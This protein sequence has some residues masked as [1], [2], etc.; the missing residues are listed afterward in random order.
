MAIDGINN[1]AFGKSSY[2]TE[3]DDKKKNHKRA[4]KI[5]A[6]VTGA[7]II[8]GGIALYKNRN[9]KPVLKFREFVKNGI[10]APLKEKDIP[11][12]KRVLNVFDN[13]K[14]GIKNLKAEKTS[15]KADY[16]DTVEISN[17]KLKNAKAKNSAAENK[18]QAAPESSVNEDAKK[19]AKAAG[20]KKTKEKPSIASKSETSDKASTLEKQEKKEGIFFKG[21]RKSNKRQAGKA[22]DKPAKTLKASSPKESSIK[23]KTAE[24]V[25]KHAKQPEPKAEPVVSAD[26]KKAASVKSLDES[27]KGK[28]VK[29]EKGIG[30]SVIE[31]ARKHAHDLKVAAGTAAVVTGGVAAGSKIG[32]IVEDKKE[33]SFSITLNGEEFN[34][35]LDSGMGFDEN[36]EPL[37]GVLT[38]MYDSGKKALITYKNGLLEQSVLFN[39]ADDTIPETIRA[40]NKDGEISQKFNK[41]KPNTAKEGNAFKSGNVEDFSGSMLCKTTDILDNKGKKSVVRHFVKN[42]DA[43][44]KII[45]K[46]IQISTLET[47]QYKGGATLKTVSIPYNGKDAVI[48]SMKKSKDNTIDATVMSPVTG[49]KLAE[50]VS[51]KNK[52]AVLYKHF[53]DGG[54][55]DGIIKIKNGRVIDINFGDGNKPL[56]ILPGYDSKLEKY[57]AKD[58]SMLEINYDDDRN[59]VS[60][61]RYST[62]NPDKMPEVET[63]FENGKVVSEIFYDEDTSDVIFKMNH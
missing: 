16:L 50:V 11:L 5:A 22:E 21:K 24:K 32:E 61:G 15:K 39:K 12:K 42:T 20:A 7:V 35:K 25:N 56:T 27:N 55:N 49:K 18:T 57:V 1:V 13:L 4:A 38:V 48:R 53:V 28:V 37:S 58:G 31:S 34:G 19:P 9:S 6:A 29:E 59:L 41:L 63:I 10:F 26:D 52:Q 17:D 44:G 40:Y 51:D 33:K 62:N 46:P 30:E 45:G 3:V 36:G 2:K 8:G 47:K 14:N 60:I 23:D 54:R 43:E